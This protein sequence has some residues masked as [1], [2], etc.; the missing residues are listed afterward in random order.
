MSVNH[1]YLHGGAGPMLLAVALVAVFYGT[2]LGYE[3]VWDDLNWLNDF[4]RLDLLA[5]LHDNLTSNTLVSFY[6]PLVAASFSLQLALSQSPLYLHGFNLVLH[7]ANLCLLVLLAR[8]THPPR[9]RTLAFAVTVLAIHPMLVEPVVWVSGRFDLFF[10]SFVLLCLLA[11]L[12]VQTGVVRFVAVAAAFLAAL[13]CKESALAYLAIGPWW[14]AIMHMAQGTT[15]PRAR[16]L[17]AAWHGGALLAALGAYLS[18]RLLWLGLPL[19]KDTAF[20]THDDYFAGEH[21]LLV[22]RTLGTYVQMTLLPLWNLAP[23][24]GQA[25]TPTAYAYISAGALVV[26]AALAGLRWRCCLPFSA[27][28]LALLPAANLVPLHID[29]VQ[30]RYLYFPLFALVLTVLKVLE[31]NSIAVPA[32]RLL[33]ALLGIWLCALAVTNLSTARLWR[34]GVS[35]FS[36]VVSVRPHSR[37]ALENLALA[38]QA[39]GQFDTA[40]EVET[41][42]PEQQRSFQGWLL[43]ARASRDADRLPAAVEYY[44][45][46][47]TVPAYDVAMHL[48]A[49]FELALVYRQRGDAQASEQLAA[50]AETLA[51]QQPV[52]KRLLDYYRGRLRP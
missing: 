45:Q 37:I 27:W 48:S 39:A 19:V 14:V 34:D 4:R 21:V 52:S 33:L 40:I 42:I 10:T 35:L 51:S 11:A 16:W 44:R 38:H 17:A 43:L 6:R 49:M 13:L 29:L 50:E 30:N 36:W 23:L 25:G 28:L 47:L 41:R 5:L 24:H 7:G 22:L 8:G 20:R 9:N 15:T 26:L 12:R 31:R 3:L 46:A 32:R 2:A 1:R 18:L